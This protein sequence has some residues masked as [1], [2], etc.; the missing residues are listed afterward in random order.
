MAQL[1]DFPIRDDLRGQKPYGAPQIRVP[2]SLNVNENT[3]RIPQAV[4]LDVVESVAAAV[5]EIN[6]YPDRE[7]VR[8][9][10]SLAGY[11]GHGLKPENI[12]AHSINDNRKIWIFFFEKILMKN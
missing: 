7:F 11:L 2:I 8:L 5:L 3:H 4:A 10:Q 6:R 1:E 9:R 12:W